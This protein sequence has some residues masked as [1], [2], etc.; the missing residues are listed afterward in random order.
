ME[1]IV[2]SFLVEFLNHLRERENVPRSPE[3]VG[4]HRRAKA[5]NPNFE[6]IPG[7]GSVENLSTSIS[8]KDTFKH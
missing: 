4:L 1:P 5:F 3:N 8:L 2:P 7:E 6:V